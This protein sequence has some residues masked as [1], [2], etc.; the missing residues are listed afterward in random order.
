VFITGG[1]GKAVVEC[2]VE[3]KDDIAKLV[4]LG[5]WLGSEGFEGLQTEDTM[6]LINIYEGELSLEDLV[7]QE[8][9]NMLLEVDEEEEHAPMDL[10]T[11]TNVQK[12]LKVCADSVTVLQNLCAEHDNGFL[13][14]GN[15]FSAPA[16][17]NLMLVE[18]ARNV[19][20]ALLV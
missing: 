19:Q 12:A 15:V 3:V 4:T 16:P 2:C 8:T 5:R 18:K 11:V 13:V 10:L 20:Q 7:E 14:S 9:M 1:F 17:C 6:Q